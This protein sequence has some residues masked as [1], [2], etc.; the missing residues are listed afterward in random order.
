MKDKPEKGGH[1]ENPVF[2]GELDTLFMIRK[3]FPEM[4]KAY[5]KISTYCLENSDKINHLS[6]TQLANKIG[7]HPSTITRFC[8][9]LNLKGY[10]ELKYKIQ[11][12]IPNSLTE[13][14]RILPTDGIHEIIKKNQT[15]CSQFISDTFTNLDEQALVR[16]ADK[17]IAAKKVCLFGHGG[18]NITAQYGQMLFVQTGVIC[19]HCYDPAMSS[20]IAAQLDK[21]DVAIAFSS[22]GNSRSC[23]DAV[24]RAKSNGAFTVAVTC[25]RSSTI[26]KTADEVL[27]YNV[28]GKR[29]FRWF[30]LLK[31]GEMATCGIL[32]T[33][34][35]NRIYPSVCN[36]LD[37][38][39]DSFWGSMH[40][41]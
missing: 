38:I 34:L 39:R 10:S 41:I 31:M 13:N 36:K 12:S 22:S 23:I 16:V 4:S 11:N 37:S 14:I 25:E 8:Q 27:L 29:D 18:S 5:K 17:M 40:H 28:N 35:L 33:V 9:F 3:L 26:A 20:G 30:Y 15:M 7:T 1:A 24:Q 32:Q 19:Y 21:E 6:I 2:E